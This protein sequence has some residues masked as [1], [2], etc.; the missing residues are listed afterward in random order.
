VQS[1]CEL[2]QISD[3]RACCLAAIRLNVRMQRTGC[4]SA[5]V[6][7]SVSQ[8]Q[9]S[10][11]LF[12]HL[13]TKSF[14]CLLHTCT[15][16]A[17]TS[18]GCNIYWLHFHSSFPHHCV[19]ARVRKISIKWLPINRLLLESISSFLT[20]LLLPDSHSSSLVRYFS[21]VQLPKT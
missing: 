14:I 15:H 9:K 10:C 1:I 12:C 4:T 17:V 8:N 19:Y 13:S 2:L 21:L 3:A 18:G 16:A 6:S 7:I 5:E 11:H 20:R